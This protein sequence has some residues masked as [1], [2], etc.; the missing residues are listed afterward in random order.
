MSALLHLIRTEIETSGPML[1]SRYMQLALAH[2]RH[3]YYQKADP[4]GTDGDFTTAPEISQLFGEMVGAWLLAAWQ[5]LGKPAPFALVELGPGR[6]TL[7]AD[8]LRVFTLDLTAHSAAKVHLVET[9]PALRTAQLKTLGSQAKHHKATH[10]S[11]L[12]TLPKIP[13]L[14]VANEFFDAL[15]TNQWVCAQNGWNARKIGI[16]D[17]SLAFGVDPT[18][19]PPPKPL[20]DVVA[21]GTILEHSPA[22]DRIARTLAQH[23]VAQGGAGLIVDYGS[24]TTGTG[25]T[26]QAVKAHQKVPPL[27]QPGNAD[28]TTHVD[29]GHI[30]RLMREAGVQHTATQEQGAFL[31][32]LGLLERAGQLGSAMT[33]QHQ[34]TIS[35]AVERLAGDAGMGRL[36]KVLG[37]ASRDMPMPGLKTQKEL[38]ER[39]S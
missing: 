32:A 1:V 29:F 15:P 23:T 30:G 27:A 11:D 12:E 37:F 17:T 2:P 19:L 13:T 39:A 24:L 5:G 6:G 35:L 10:H 25:D 31:L 28:L 26:L 7:M 21:H 14:W 20:S 3:G 18:P 34:E 4:L 38:N 33:A 36:F 9:S 22:Q 8:I 16:A